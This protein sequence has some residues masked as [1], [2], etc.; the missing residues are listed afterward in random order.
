MQVTEVTEVTSLKTLT[1]SDRGRW[2][3]RCQACYARPFCNLCYLA[4]LSRGYGRTRVR[5]KV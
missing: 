3:H 1:G 5:S 2:L 4:E